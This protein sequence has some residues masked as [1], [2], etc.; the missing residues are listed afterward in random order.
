MIT[1]TE[2]QHKQKQDI[3][4]L[5]A[6]SPADTLFPA[7]V[8]TYQAFIVPLMPI[9]AKS[10]ADI[11][12]FLQF[13][14]LESVLKTVQDKAP[15]FTSLLAHV[16]APFCT[17]NKYLFIGLNS[18]FLTYAKAVAVQSLGYW[19]M[20]PNIFYDNEGFL[21]SILKIITLDPEF[22]LYASMLAKHYKEHTA[23]MRKYLPKFVAL[24]NAI[25]DV[26]INV[27][28][29]IGYVSTSAFMAFLFEL[30]Q[31]DPTI[32]VP[33]V[34]ET[35][36]P[37]LENAQICSMSF[38][39]LKNIAKNNADDVVPYLD[40]IIA[41]LDKTATA[42]IFVPSIMQSVIT[43]GHVGLKKRIALLDA[44]FSFFRDDAMFLMMKAALMLSAAVMEVASIKPY[45]FGMIKTK[46]DSVLD[47]HKESNEVAV[48][49]NIQYTCEYIENDQVTSKRLQLSISDMYRTSNS[50]SAKFDTM[51]S[52]SISFDDFL[53]MI[54]M[55]LVVASDKESPEYNLV[56]QY[57]DNKDH[58]YVRI[59]NK[60]ALDYVLQSEQ[61]EEV[62]I[63]VD[64]QNANVSLSFGEET[65]PLKEYLSCKIQYAKGDVIAQTNSKNHCIIYNCNI[66]S[67]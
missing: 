13:T 25:K 45:L 4:Y 8:L 58:E 5:L 53:E 26:K 54:Q 33:Y 7:H 49:T 57:Y 19:V 59:Q 50:G 10:E 61:L 16:F 21:E 20:Q 1:Y 60:E 55:H 9:H 67:K 17:Q 28:Q 24:Y 11:V 39:M 35:V 32:I 27:S 47:K 18:I 36:L 52:N 42:V 38:A 62:S 46:Y 51:V 56:I 48:R 31:H 63:A 66:I 30:S 12:E 43:Y 64:A 22:I 44:M 37:T 3:L 41:S 40:T 6:H 65:V 15:Q 23:L 29:H 2:A 34:T 14:E